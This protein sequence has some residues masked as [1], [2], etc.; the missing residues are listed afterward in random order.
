MPLYRSRS[1]S[2]PGQPRAKRGAVEINEEG[3]KK[4]QRKENQCAIHCTDETTSLASLKDL[5]SW[6]TLLNAAV[7]RN[8]KGILDIAK[9]VKEGELPQISYHRKCRSIFTLKRDLEKLSQT[10]IKV[11]EQDSKASPRSSPRQ[12]TT[13]QG[14][15]YQRICV[16]CEKS[17]YLKGTKTR[18][19][20]IQCVD[21]RADH[22]IRRAAV[23]KNDPRI[24]AIVTRELV[25]AEACYHKT[26]YRDYTR[27]VQ[28]QTG[29]G[30]NAEDEHLDCSNAES[31]A[32]MI[33]YD[34]IRSDLLQNPKIVSMTQLYMKFAS[35]VNSQGVKE[36][37]DSTRTHFRRKLEAEFH[38]T[39]DFEELFGNNKV[40]VIPRSLSRL[41]LARFA[42]DKCNTDEEHR[43]P[44]SAYGKQSRDK[45]AKCHGRLNLVN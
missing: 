22:T 13:P 18:E 35:F 43:K 29:V 39:L 12:P 11:E 36:V 25:A 2:A 28:D 20:L 9:T 32:F 15:V 19:A 37:K 14:R 33:L 23:S 6:K 24:L 45:R 38:D 26:C 10:P 17:K 7:I 16:F 1:C 34:Y 30:K 4:R 41:D 5:D 8:H 44:R 27:D 3:S 21:L 42:A 40:F 31:Q